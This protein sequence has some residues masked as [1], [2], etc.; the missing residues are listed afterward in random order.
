[1]INGGR[2]FSALRGLR[3]GLMS[4]T[5]LGMPIS[6]SPKAVDFPMLPTRTYGRLHPDLY[7]NFTT[8]IQ[9][10]TEAEYDIYPLL[11]RKGGGNLYPFEYYAFAIDEVKA[12]ANV[13]Y[14]YDRE[15]DFANQKDVLDS[16][17]NILNTLNYRGSESLSSGFMKSEISVY[18]SEI[19]Y[20]RNGPNS[21]WILNSEVPK[22]WLYTTI[23]NHGLSENV[24][25]VREV[26]IYSSQGG[27]NYFSFAY[28]ERRWG[29]IK[30]TLYDNAMIDSVTTYNSVKNNSEDEIYDTEETIIEF[31]DTE[32]LFEGNL[33]RDLFD[34]P[35]FNNPN[36]SQQHFVELAQN[37][38]FGRTLFKFKQFA[39]SKALVDFFLQ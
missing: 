8:D 4:S 25:P 30:Y 34:I 27:N 33:N 32:Q 18:Y 14:I 19:G 36:P 9:P 11:T 31:G 2:Y 39:G 12:I 7:P 37:K 28:Q 22:T 29:E 10:K 20:I 15:A 6:P 21:P 1:M 38:T 23:N 13:E 24:N 17:F 3:R 5:E 26:M 35:P 16:A